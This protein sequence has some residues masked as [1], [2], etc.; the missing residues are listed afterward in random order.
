[1]QIYGPYLERLYSNGWEFKARHQPFFL[2]LTSSNVYK[3]TAHTVRNRT[4]EGR[5]MC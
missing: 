3:S 1:M 5:A 4:R 2:F